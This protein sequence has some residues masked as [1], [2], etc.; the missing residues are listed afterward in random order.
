M[1]AQPRAHTVAR[2]HVRLDR[3]P[4]EV[5][6]PTPAPDPLE[7][8]VAT[9]YDRYA[10]P[11]VCKAFVENFGQV[12]TFEDLAVAAWGDTPQVREMSRLRRVRQYSLSTFV[13]R[14]NARLALHKTPYVI[15]NVRGVGYR[16]Q[17][18]T[19]KKLRKYTPR[20]RAVLLRKIAEMKAA[21]PNMSQNQICRRLGM[22]SK[23]LWGWRTR[24][25]PTE[26]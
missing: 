21:H 24:G 9:L 5:N 12:L 14:I 11:L 20:E 22:S 18:G 8:L 2:G 4:V 1:S 25:T 23:T 19:R 17:H 7:T 10:E 26:S 6:E 3:A 16:M 15:V 13:S